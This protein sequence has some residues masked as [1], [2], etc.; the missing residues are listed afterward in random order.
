M[1]DANDW[2][3]EGW[4]AARRVAP[5]VRINK[6]GF[7][8]VVEATYELA[9]QRMSVIDRMIS[10]ENQKADHYRR[11]KDRRAND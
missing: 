10:R 1:T 2:K 11:S 7:A 3:I 8:E 4:L 9:Q 5:V 6:D